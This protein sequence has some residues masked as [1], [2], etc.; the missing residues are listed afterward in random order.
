MLVAWVRHFERIEARPNGHDDIGE[1]LHLHVARAWTH[2]DAV[3]GVMAHALGR[4]IAQRVIE[5]FDAAPG[6]GAR[7]L[8]VLVG[9][10]HVMHGKAGI[11]DLHLEA[12]RDDGLVFLAHRL[13]YRQDM[14]LVAL[15]VAVLHES[16]AA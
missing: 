16:G 6:P 9:V 4:D 8:Y 5:N 11:V 15:V 14:L 12:S 13:R 2:V 7:L 10:E 1:M 3:T